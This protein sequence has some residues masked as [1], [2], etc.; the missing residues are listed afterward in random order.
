[1]YA[2]KRNIHGVEGIITYVLQLQINHNS[3]IGCMFLVAT[4]SISILSDNL[5]I[6]V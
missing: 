4:L 1:M 6:S 3:T 2:L 5:P